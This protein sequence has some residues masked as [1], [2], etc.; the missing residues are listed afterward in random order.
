MVG[1][2][3]VVLCFEDLA[4]DDGENA[5]LESLQLRNPSLVGHIAILKSIAS[6]TD[7]GFFRF[8]SLLH[9]ASR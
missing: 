9:E 4:G 8:D 5:I 6:L 2:L 3:H 7:S 1:C